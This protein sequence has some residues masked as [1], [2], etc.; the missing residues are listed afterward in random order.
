MHI[1]SLSINPTF[2]INTH[3]AAKEAVLAQ[4][5]K[6]KVKKK[7]GFFGFGGKTVTKE[8]EEVDAEQDH[9][10]RE[11]VSTGCCG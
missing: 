3:R 2:A 10:D 9:D 1:F 8:E 6:D 4:R 11:E 7:G 5:A